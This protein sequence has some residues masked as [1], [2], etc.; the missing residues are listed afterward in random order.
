MSLTTADLGHAVVGLRVTAM[1]IGV[2]R[3]LEVERPAVEVWRGR[4]MGKAPHEYEQRGDADD[5]DDSADVRRANRNG[6]LPLPGFERHAHAACERR[7]EAGARRLLQQGHAPALRAA[8]PRVY[9]RPTGAPRGKYADRENERGENDHADA[10]R[11]EVDVK[12]DVGIGQASATDREER[13]HGECKEHCH[14]DAEYGHYDSNEDADHGARAACHAERLQ[15]RLVDTGLGNLTS[16]DDRDRHCAGQPSDGREDPQRQRQHVDRVGGTTV[17]ARQIG[18]AVERRGPEQ[19][20]SRRLD[21]W[22]IA[23][24]GGRADAQ[25]VGEHT[26]ATSRQTVERRC[27]HHDAAGSGAVTQ[28]ERSSDDADD[29]ERGAR[30]SAAG[31]VHDPLR[32]RRVARA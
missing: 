13:R 7:R 21:L 15:R 30:T 4:E 27:Q 24:A 12:P 19:S 32:P 5:A 10:D 6:P 16:E 31:R 14:C 17:F 26:D 23:S 22:N 18:R 28:I 3:G 20:L 1:C 11:H 8:P 9:R 2:V 29:R 25:D